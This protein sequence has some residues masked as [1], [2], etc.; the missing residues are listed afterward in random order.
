MFRTFW[1][2][3]GDQ[4]NAFHYTYLNHINFYNSLAIYSYKVNKDTLT[5][6][7]QHK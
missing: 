5:L 2:R 4:P 1:D 7:C 6:E 3:A